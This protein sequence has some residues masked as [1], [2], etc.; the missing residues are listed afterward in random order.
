MR[1]L[2]AFLRALAPI[3]V[4]GASLGTTLL[5]G[6]GLLPGE[7]DETAGW[8]P[9]KLYTE[10]KQAVAEGGDGAPI[11]DRRNWVEPEPVAFGRLAAMAGLMRTGLDER[12]LLTQEQSDL[13]RDVESLFTFFQ[14]VAQ[15][16]LAGQPISEALVRQEWHELRRL[17]RE[18]ERRAAG[19]P[20][21]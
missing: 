12:E 8:S 18:Y 2:A 4:I 1:S 13:L 3:V 5:G 10:A 16:E 14:E 17:R 7:V 20:P 11:P 15:D 6:C 21:R 19:D 9:N